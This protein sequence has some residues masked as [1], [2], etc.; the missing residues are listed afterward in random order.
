MLTICE[1]ETEMFKEV[2]LIGVAFLLVHCKTL[3]SPTK[4]NDKTKAWTD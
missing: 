3:V 1:R 4:D 2:P